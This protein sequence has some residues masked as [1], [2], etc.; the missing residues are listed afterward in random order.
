MKTLYISKRTSLI[1]LSFIILMTGLQ[2]Q[3][4]Y[5]HVPRVKVKKQSTE[6]GVTKVAE[7]SSD[8]TATEYTSATMLSVITSPNEEIDEMAVASSS[9]EVALV[10]H[11][12]KI[13]VPNTEKVKNNRKFDRQSFTE[14]VKVKSKLLD[15]KDVKKTAILGYII[16]LIAV[17]IICVILFVVAYLFLYLVIFSLHYVFLSFGILAAVI[18]ALILILG[19]T[20]VIA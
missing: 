17:I 1:I 14:Q 2:A 11:K 3:S 13:A 10:K 12:P 15:V 18:I 7:P 5:R 19:L 4:R 8:P 6:L 16:W 9:N 20:G